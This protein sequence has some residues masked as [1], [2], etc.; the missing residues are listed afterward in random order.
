MDLLNVLS[1]TQ[2]LYF[3]GNIEEG[4]EHFARWLA[5]EKK[6][7]FQKCSI[8][9]TFLNAEETLFYVQMPQMLTVEQFK[10]LQ[11]RMLAALPSCSFILCSTP[12]M[13]FICN[14]LGESQ[15]FSFPLIEKHNV[16]ILNSKKMEAGK[17]L[18]Q[19]RQEADD[20]LVHCTLLRELQANKGNVSA[21][22]R[23]LKM[24]RANLLRLFKKMGLHPNDFRENSKPVEDLMNIKKA[25]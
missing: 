17:S 19:M 3:H 8:H 5:V 10:A 1:G 20:Q 7:A 25:A 21:I 4:K 18:S 12:A 11:Q 15:C 6:K 9:D 22:A 16:T 23:H 14:A 13:D 24:D 2:T